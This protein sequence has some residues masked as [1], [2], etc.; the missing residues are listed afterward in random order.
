MA[1]S[2]FSESSNSTES[3]VSD[4]KVD[5]DTSDTEEFCGVSALQTTVNL[6]K[7]MIG[8][9]M[10]SLA[11]GLGN[12]TG[13]VV[14]VIICILFAGLM[15]YSFSLLGRVCHATKSKTLVGCCD[16]V[17]VGH[18]WVGQAM[19]LSITLLTYLACT[20]FCIIIGDNASQ[21]SQAFGM[22]GPTTSYRGALLTV[23]ILLE[24]PL[25]L[26]RDM[27]KLAVT[28]LI[29]V[30]CE[31]GVIAFMGVRAF[32]GTYH[33]GGEYY[34]EPKGIDPSKS[35]EVHP[36]YIS[37][38]TFTLVCSLATA[39]IA[40]FQAPK[41]YHQLRRR[42][43]KRFNVVTLSSFG[44]ASFM[45]VCSMSFGY[46]AFGVNCDGNI[47]NNY[48]KDDPFATTART[49]MLFAV[50]FGFPVVFTGLRDSVLEAFRLRG[51]R[52]RSWFSCTV[53]ILAPCVILS[54]IV[55]DL[56]TFNQLVGAI[57][58]AVTTLTYPAILCYLTFKT[59]GVS[60][61]SS[62]EGRI[63]AIVLFLTSLVLLFGG[64]AVVILT[65]TGNM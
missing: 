9:G 28:S 31:L 52:R 19:A 33:T 25:C 17:A 27:S 44:L 26:I 53:V 43:V 14:G 8:E 62:F 64:T 45:F 59:V 6:A 35:E 11:A 58:G 5:V 13:L 40:H 51:K 22:D 63:G 7:C 55:T 2:D 57:L 16:V 10:L 30:C 12:E 46:L 41:F 48:S 34:T 47:L 37:T 42:S 29:G 36:L 4:Q 1:D 18:P 24:L 49:G 23:I 15:S 60:F 56:G 50:C 65:H 32:D 61:S 21:I 38:G 3:A 39:Y 54:L 20:S